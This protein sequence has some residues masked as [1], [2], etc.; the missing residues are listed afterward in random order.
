MLFHPSHHVDDLA[1]AEDFFAR[2]FQQRSTAMADL[3]PNGLPDDYPTD[4]CTFTPIRD[5]LFDTIDPK[6]YVVGGVQRYPTVKRPHLKAMGWYL[7]GIGE[8]YRELKRQGI[9][10]ISQLDELHEGEEPPSAANSPMPMFFTVPAD[11][12]LRYEFMPPTRFPPDPRVRPGWRLPPVQDDDPLGLVRC[13]HHTIL[14]DQPERQLR[15]WVDIMGAAV[16]H[17]GRDE[18][19]GTTG[20]YVHYA[21]TTLA[22]ATPDPGTAAEADWSENASVLMLTSSD[23][24][25]TGSSSPAAN[26]TY[27]AITWTVLDLERAARHLVSQGVEILARSGTSLVTDPATSLGVPWGFTVD[28]VPGDPRA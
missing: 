14:T 22:F 27:H 5:V 23:A 16:V 13:S 8:L 15:F 2:V 28:S 9:R 21:G 6:R 26:D 18:V 3:Y 12:G 1:E 11:V 10:V 20:T 4:Y 19:R 24:A 25:V 7:D 17:Q